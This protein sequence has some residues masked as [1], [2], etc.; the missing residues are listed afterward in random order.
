MR[1]NFPGGPRSQHKSGPRPSP[2]V[3]NCEYTYNPFKRQTPNLVTSQTLTVHRTAWSVNR[4]SSNSS[5]AAKTRA[6]KREYQG[7]PLQGL[8]PPAWCLQSPGTTT[9]I[10]RGGCHACRPRN[11]RCGKVRRFCSQ[12]FQEEN[13][14]FPIF[15]KISSPFSIGFLSFS[16]GLLLPIVRKLRLDKLICQKT[17]RSRSYDSIK[18]PS[19]KQSSVMAEVYMKFTDLL[20]AVTDVQ[21]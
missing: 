3:N 15:F 19:P 10:P 14:S 11:M 4:A 13:I 12:I 2:I 21:L 20:L 9:A 17:F 1:G 18:C 7:K 8:V 5:K 16:N 6:F